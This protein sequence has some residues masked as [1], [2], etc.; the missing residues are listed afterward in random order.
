MRDLLIACLKYVRSSVARTSFTKHRKFA[1]LNLI[2]EHLDLFISCK[3]SANICN[4]RMEV[5]TRRE[6]SA[7]WKSTP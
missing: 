6:V 1:F 4:Y 2:T 7:E 5:I 3:V